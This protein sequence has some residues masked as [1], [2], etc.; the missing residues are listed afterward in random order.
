MTD[1]ISKNQRSELMRAVKSKG[2]L[3]TEIALIEVFKKR[4]I[5]GWRRNYKLPGKPDF[6]F[7]KLRIALFADGCF[8]HGHNCRNTKPATNIDYWQSKIQRNI[9]RDREVE[10]ELTNRGWYVVR[11]WECE[12]KKGELDKLQVIEDAIS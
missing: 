11:V 12:I 2:N 8:W 5:K 1:R 10:K 6:V 4:G 3:S 9:E 7:P